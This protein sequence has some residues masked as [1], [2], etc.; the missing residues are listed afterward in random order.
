MNIEALTQ[1]LNI[2]LEKH[3][4]TGAIQ[5]TLSGLL[6][7]AATPGGRMLIERAHAGAV[8]FAVDDTGSTAFSRSRTHLP[9][10]GALLNQLLGSIPPLQL[11]DLL[12]SVLDEISAARPPCSCPKCVA[13]RGE[14]SSAHSPKDK[15]ALEAAFTRADDTNCGSKH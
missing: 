8:L 3:G 14:S 2:A 1:D 4:I 9:V 11:R 12:Q 5:S 15:G 13:R 6:G 7:L 10:N